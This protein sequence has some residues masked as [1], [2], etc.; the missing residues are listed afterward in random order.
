MS[1]L[2][3]VG[4]ALATP[5]MAP[6]SQERGATSESDPNAGLTNNSPLEFAPITAGDRAGAAILTIIICVSLV[7][8]M[9][10]IV[11]GE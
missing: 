1:A 4:A 11:I 6:L 8:T 10:W 5:D 9:I 3:V 2:S 7:G